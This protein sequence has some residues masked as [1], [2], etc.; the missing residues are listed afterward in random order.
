[1]VSEMV[2]KFRAPNAVPKDVKL[3]FVTWLYF[4]A[5]MCIIFS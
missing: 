1:M 2:A 4:I 3:T 5:V